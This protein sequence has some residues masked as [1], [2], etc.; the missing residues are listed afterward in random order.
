MADPITM[1]AQSGPGDELGWLVDL[2]CDGRLANACPKAIARTKTRLL[3]LRRER[4]ES[5]AEVARLQ[6]FMAGGNFYTWMQN[7]A[8]ERDEAR[9]ALA[10]AYPRA[11]QAAA[12]VVDEHHAAWVES[13]IGYTPDLEVLASEI[14][15]LTPE[16]IG[17]I[18]KEH[19]HG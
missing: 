11:L 7:A 18:T 2:A 3:D 15:A 4:D 6:Q 12:G 9:A 1:R 19:E 5:L 16:D 8:R 10:L 17:R 14:R 13:D